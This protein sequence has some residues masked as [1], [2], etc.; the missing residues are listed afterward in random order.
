P[1]GLEPAARDEERAG[2][3]RARVFREVADARAG[4]AADEADAIDPPDEFLEPHG[5]ASRACTHRS[6]IGGAGDSWTAGRREAAGG[7]R[8]REPGFGSRQSEKRRVRPPVPGCRL[9][10]AGSPPPESRIPIPESRY[11]ITIASP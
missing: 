9:P 7:N 4:V 11:R 5:D 10:V 8:R 3:G 1:V 6:L 2:H